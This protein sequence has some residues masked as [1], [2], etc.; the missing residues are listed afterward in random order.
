MQPQTAT[1]IVGALGIGGTL[2]GIICGHLLTR[3]WQ[4]KQW[5]LDRRADEF[6]ELLTALSDSLRV[7][8]LMHSGGALGPNEQ[9]EIANA[10][11]AAIRVIRSRIFVFYDIAKL[12]IELRWIRAVNAHKESLDVEPLAKVFNEIRIQIVDA[13]RKDADYQKKGRKLQRSLAPRLGK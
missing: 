12:D 5:L 6:R 4:R 1:L 7:S 11:S 3:S 2:G 9:R 8:M 13:V 10:H